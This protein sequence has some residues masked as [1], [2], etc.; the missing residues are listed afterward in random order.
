MIRNRG[1]IH[2]RAAVFLKNI[3][4]WVSLP[5]IDCAEFSPRQLCHNI[6]GTQR[7]GSMAADTRAPLLF[8]SMKR[9]GA[10]SLDVARMTEPKAAL[11]K[12]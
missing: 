11:D 12:N 5:A 8:Q 7:A 4:G 9:K 2:D 3:V 10:S 6:E 1:T